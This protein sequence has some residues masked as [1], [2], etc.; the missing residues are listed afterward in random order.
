MPYL[1]LR[2]GESLFYKDWGNKSAQV[3]L[4]SHGWPLN[5]DNFELQMFFL[6][7]HGYRVV[8]HDR[9]GHGRSSQPWF[10]NDID[11]WADDLSELIEHLDL[12]GITIIGHS[13]G[14][15]E[16]ARYVGRHGISRLSKA[17]MISTNPPIMMQ[18][19]NNP[20]G[21]P[22]AVFDS[23]R[24][25]MLKD[26]AQFFIDVASGPFFGYNREGAKKSQ[27]LIDSWVQAGLICSLPAV[28]ECTRTWQKDYTEDLKMMDFPV[29]VLVG[30]DDQI[31]PY[32]ASS[33]KIV[34]VVP[35]GR[36][37]VYPGAPHAI[38]NTHTDEVNKDILAFL[39]EK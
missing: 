10:G 39:Q 8:A 5:S 21:T 14:G 23:F 37:K 18:T 34:K 28:Y 17:V 11:T 1:T 29:L 19:N 13:T 16:I 26:R 15:G 9:R 33:E 2:D 12:N 36:L 32:K 20:E 7:H 27:G 4:F 25:A 31:V 22:P 3:V 35:N 6:G 24:E 38:P 30:D